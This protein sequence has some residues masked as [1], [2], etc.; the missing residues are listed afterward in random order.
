MAVAAVS[1]AVLVAM[2]LALPAAVVPQCCCVLC[3]WW[4]L[5][6]RAEAGGDDL[7]AAAVRAAV[8][9]MGL[10]GLPLVANLLPDSFPVAAE[11]VSAVRVAPA[12][13]LPDSFPAAAAVAAAMKGM[14]LVL[15]RW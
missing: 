15:P 5:W 12:L 14:L 10:M 3:W 9:L 1:N 4:R 7:M 8:D 11:A 6:W 13:L 2:R